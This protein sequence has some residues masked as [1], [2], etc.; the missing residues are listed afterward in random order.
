MNGLGKALN[1]I[2]AKARE[3]SPPAPDDV[4][5]NGLRY[6]A[7]C[8]AA[9]ETRVQYQGREIKVPCVCA[10]KEKEYEEAEQRRRHEAEMDS[11]AK[12]KD[13]S[14]MNSKYRNASFDSYIQRPENLRAYRIARNY[15]DRFLSTPEKEGLYEK[16]QG[17][18]FYGTVGTGKSYTAAC[19]ANDLLARGVSV[20]MTSFVKLLQDGINGGET[21]GE[22]LSRLNKAKLLIIDDL[23]AERNTEYALEKVY[24]IIDSRCREAKPMI[25]TTNLTMQDITGA[26]DI[27]LRRIY[28]R[29]LECCYPI[30]LTGQSFRMNEAA[31][32]QKDMKTLLED[33]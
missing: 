11:L 24:N 18:L 14:L 15:C 3:A 28:D 31:K 4:I 29:I 6:C 27:R 23:G 8:G 33:F 25:L 16:G 20:V 10:C 12:L 1:G 5:K 9:K 7:K 2:V 13:A 30:Q 22:S 32:R 26:T 19:I 17:L 21:E